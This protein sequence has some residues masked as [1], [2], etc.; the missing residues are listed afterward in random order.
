MMDKRKKHI[1]VLDDD[2]AMLDGIRMSLKAEPSYAITVCNDPHDAIAIMQSAE[3]NLVISDIMMP[4]LSGLD[5]LGTIAK[6]DPNVPVVLITGEPDQERM[7]TAIQLG[8]FDFLRKPFELAELHI[9]VKQALQ[10]NQ[11]LIQNESY[12]NHLENL[13]EERTSELLAAKNKLEK[14]LSKYHPCHGK[15]GGSQRCLYPRTF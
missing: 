5:V 13:V 8:A 6:T 11:L 12:R 2:L 1:L 7:R 4:G 3:F 10:K 15:C 9:A 14:A